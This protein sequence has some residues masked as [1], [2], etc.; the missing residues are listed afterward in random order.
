[1]D[2]AKQIGKISAVGFSNN[3]SITVN[4][5]GDPSAKLILLDNGNV[6]INYSVGAGETEYAEY[7]INNKKLAKELTDKYN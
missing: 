2:D 3:V 7:S 4:Y 6:A 5:N 1:M